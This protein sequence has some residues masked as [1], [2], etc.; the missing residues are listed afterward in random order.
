MKTWGLKKRCAPP[1]YA[2]GEKS[3]LSA[4][5]RSPASRLQRKA[6]RTKN[7][8]DG[9]ARRESI[10]GKGL[11]LW[12]RERAREVS[13]RHAVIVPS[14]INWCDFHKNSFKYTPEIRGCV[15]ISKLHIGVVS[16]GA[17]NSK[18]GTKK[19]EKEKSYTLSRSA[20]REVRSRDT[21]ILP[22]VRFLLV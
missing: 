2:R 22:F 6:A 21:P 9:R 1:I 3:A 8:R 16:T 11:V 4:D 7:F 18:E 12:T 10:S 20:Y 13:G 14:V 15:S 5:R 19:K 17:A